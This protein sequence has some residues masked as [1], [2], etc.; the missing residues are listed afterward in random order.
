MNFSE[1]KI[2]QIIESIKN[3]RRSSARDSD[4]MRHTKSR[5]RSRE[6]AKK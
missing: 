6:E 5:K 1:R 2:I 3:R 4:S